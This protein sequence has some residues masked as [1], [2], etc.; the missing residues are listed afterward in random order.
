MADGWR[1]DPGRHPYP[2]WR[3][4]YVIEPPKDEAKADPPEG[5]RKVPFG[6]GVR[7]AEAEA[8]PAADGWEG[9][10]S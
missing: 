4:I 5:A 6:F 2:S 7:E 1:W 10:P 8:A 3:S 9:N